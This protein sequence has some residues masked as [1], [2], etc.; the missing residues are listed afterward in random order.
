MLPALL[1]GG[2]SSHYGINC[3]ALGL[4][5]SAPA[6]IVI[7]GAGPAALV[8]AHRFLR[9]TQD[10]A[11]SGIQL[12][13][14]EKRPRPLRYVETVDA[15]SCEVGDNAFGFGLSSRSQMVLNKTEG[16]LGKLHAISQPTKFAPGIDLRLINRR[17]LCAELLYE[18]EQEFGGAD[19]RSKGGNR[20]L[21]IC[22]DTEVV[23]I[24]DDRELLIRSDSDETLLNYSLLIGADGANSIVRSKLVEAGLLQCERYYAPS[25]WKAL[26]LPEQPNLDASSFVRYPK[27][28]YKPHK[29]IKK[30]NG[31][32]LPRFPNRHVLLNFRA[33]TDME[34]A[35]YPFDAKTPEQLKEAIRSI[36]GNVT[37]FP[38]DA[39]LQKFLNQKPGLEAYMKLDRHYV[40]DRNVVLVG[41]AAVGMYSLFGQGAANAMVHADLLAETLAGVYNC[42]ETEAAGSKLRVS[43]DDQHDDG[44]QASRV[45]VCLQT[46]SATAVKEGH[47][48][49]ELNLLTHALRK[50]GPIKLWAGLQMMGIGKTLSAHPE[51]K[52]DK[53]RRKWRISIWISKLFWKRT[54]I[55][56]PIT[57][58]QRTSRNKT[59]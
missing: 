13:L 18:L 57:S 42:P 1:S 30:D 6:P 14:L 41:D 23:D 22:F 11:A 56:A 46:Y 39:V 34:A 38:S 47:A 12:V 7:S 53:I 52:Y 43:E 44:S 25:T 24:T 2:L 19:Q 32:I 16:L 27:P 10:S 40:P 20:R 45:E 48:I 3:L 35:R 49:S 29:H 5:A 31:A 21:K 8:F 15:P 50:K 37:N 33:S 4:K 59:N 26:Q 58:T 55:E 17:E 54:R 9:L 51:M 28:Y 36:N